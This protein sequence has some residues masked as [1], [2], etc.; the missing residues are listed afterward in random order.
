[1]LENDEFIPCSACIVFTLMVSQEAEDNQEFKDLNEERNKI[2]TDCRKNFDDFA[3]SLW[4]V[5]KQCLVLLQK[6]SNIN[7][8][9]SAFLLTYKG[10]L[11][12]HLHCND[13]T[14]YNAYKRIHFILNFPKFNV[15][16]HNTVNAESNATAQ[17]LQQPATQE[18]VAEVMEEEPEEETATA[19]PLPDFTTFVFGEAGTSTTAPA[20]VVTNDNTTTTPA[21]TNLNNYPRT[22]NTYVNNRTTPSHYTQYA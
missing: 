21:R 10:E 15:H 1:M 5:T 7:K 2:I 3:K 13:T 8:T 4:F 6:K 22:E 18:V 9:V 20:P 19:Q 16:M 17:L 11:L 14:L 12:Q